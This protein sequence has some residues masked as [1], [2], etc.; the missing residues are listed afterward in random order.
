[1]KD[2]IKVV[3]FML[4]VTALATTAMTGVKVALDARIARNKTLAEKRL[5]LLAFNLL[6]DAADGATVDRLYAERITTEE[7]AGRTIYRAKSDDPKRPLDAVGFDVVGTGL[8]GPIHAMLALD[9]DLTTLVG[10]V[11]M[12]H[13]ETPGLGG[14]ITEPAFRAQFK[15]KR[16]DQPDSEGRYVLFVPES[17]TLSDPNREVHAI[18]GATN[19]TNGVA[20]ILNRKLAVV[21]SDLLKAMQAKDRP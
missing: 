2:R 7:I 13:Q 8:W 16:V 17:A 3:A 6:P 10:F 18:S 5:R 12:S 9:A 14:R 1:M 15:D 19:T 11:V 21:R 4:V 20:E